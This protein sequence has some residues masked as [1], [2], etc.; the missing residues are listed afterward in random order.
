MNAM[1]LAAGRGE[2]MRPL[3][4]HCPK[5]LLTVGGRTLLDWHL[6][7][8]A[9]AGCRRVVINVA[10]LGQRIRDFVGD[11]SAWGLEVLIS[12]EGDQALETAGGIIRALPWLG[13]HPFW[14]VN[15]DVW[16]D[17]DFRTLSSA[18]EGL[19]ELVLVENPS[20]HPR[21]DFHL[22]AASSVRTEGSGQRL[23]FAGI[24]CY[25]PDLFAGQ[26][27]AHAP[28]G[29]LLKRAADRRQLTGV[30][31]TGAWFDIGTPARLARLDSWLSAGQ[32]P[33]A[34][35]E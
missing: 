24:G 18:P 14:V 13:P 6:A 3:T 27:T 30:Q 1:I 25:R 11:G 9:D 5:P 21:G 28:L 10:W 17:F 8:L 31:H 32:V 22:D 19:A 20:H 29:P 34:A 26:R 12:D 23:T 4:D 2:R 16:S 7:R 35:D 33:S 15:G